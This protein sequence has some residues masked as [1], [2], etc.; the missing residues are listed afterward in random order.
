MGIK[1]RQ[2]LCLFSISFFTVLILVGVYV[3]HFTLLLG[4]KFHATPFFIGIIMSSTGLANAITCS[5]FGKLA[6]RYSEKKLIKAAL[7]IYLIPLLIIP[8]VH[9]VWLFLISTVLLGIA[10]GMRRPSIQTLLAGFAPIEHRAI[11]MSI[12]G[13]LGGLGAL[14]GPLLMAAIFIFSGYEGVFFA[15]A[16]LTFVMLIL[17]LVVLK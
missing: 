5:Q 8:F 9:N 1:N 14:L 6:K 17:A 4:D 15:C 12:K 3:V 13:M 2:V 10:E 7:V 16:G 11:F